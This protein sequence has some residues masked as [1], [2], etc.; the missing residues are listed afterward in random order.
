M[1]KTSNHSWDVQIS[2]SDSSRVI[3]MAQPL[4]RLVGKEQ[5][6]CGSEQEQ[7]FERLKRAM[8]SA[9]VLAMPKDKD[10]VMIQMQYI[11]RCPRSHPIT[12]TRQQ[13]ETSGLLV[14]STK[15]KGTK[16]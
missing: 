6:S 1:K 4:T 15:Q 10:P 13:M 8:S 5:W 11:R 16:L 2:T 12:K 14:Q 9:L 7:A 3:K